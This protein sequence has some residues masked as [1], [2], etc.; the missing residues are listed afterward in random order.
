MVIRILFVVFLLLISNVFAQLK[1]E[2]KTDTTDYLIGDLINLQIETNYPKDYKLLEPSFKDS[3]K[4]FEIINEIETNY[5]TVEN[6]VSFKKNFVLSYYDSAIVSIP[7]FTFIF[8]S[9]LDT[10]KIY[11]DSVLIKVHS[12]PIEAGQDIKDVKSPILIPLDIVEIILWV[13]LALALITATYFLI[14]KFRKKKTIESKEPEIV[15]PCH[16][17]ALA[18]L[19]ELE[20]ERLW[21]SG[22]VKEYHSRITGIVREYF[23]KR[24]Q[25]PALELTSSEQIEHLEK[26]PEA[27]EILK[28]TEEF[29]TNADLVK[30]AKFNPIPDLNQIMMSQAKEIVNSTAEKEQVG[31]SIKAEVENVQ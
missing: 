7:S 19:D 12:L 18:K 25:F 26:I 15:L 3:L 30:F 6:L 20:R 10:N 29:F 1:V 16:V 17:V 24:F 4:K 27:N 9:G 5:D 31:N 13:L 22:K 11:S 2:V 28:T 8:I 21:Q 23:E 14:K